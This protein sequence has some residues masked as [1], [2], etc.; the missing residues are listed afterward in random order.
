MFGYFILGYGII[1]FC[2]AMGMVIA[3][4]IEDYQRKKR[5]E[6]ALNEPIVVKVSI[7]DEVMESVGFVGSQEEFEELVKNHLTNRKNYDIMNTR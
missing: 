1:V 2:Q 5:L 6:K 3:D 7:V 4:K